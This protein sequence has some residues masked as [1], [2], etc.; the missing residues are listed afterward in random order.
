MDIKNSEESIKEGGSKYISYE[1]IVDTND[2]DNMISFVKETFEK[3]NI[4]FEYI[5]E[6]RYIFIDRNL[7][8]DKDSIYREIYKSFNCEHSKNNKEHMLLLK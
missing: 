4:P 2:I 1:F 3:L 5:Y 7:I 6:S 8:C